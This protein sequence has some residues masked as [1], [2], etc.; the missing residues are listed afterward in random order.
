MDKFL[1]L[2]NQFKYCP[3]AFHIDTY[4]G[5]PFGCKYCF[6]NTR[7]GGFQK[8]RKNEAIDSKYLSRP[9][10]K[11]FESDK[12]FKDITVELLQHKVPLHL[13]GMSDPFQPREFSE[14]KTYELLELS[15]KHQYPIMISTKVDHLPDEYWAI[16][17]PKIHAFQVSLC[18]M[19]DDFIRRYE[20]HTPSPLN[21]V[22]FIKELRSRGFWVSVRIQP[23]IELNEALK[24]VETVNDFVN[25]ITVEH[26]KIPTDNYEIRDLFADIKE[27]YPYIKPKKSRH[28]ELTT[29]FKLKNIQK[30]KA[31]AKCPVGCAD[32]DLHRYS[33]SKCCCGVDCVGEAF[34]NYLKYNTCYF[35]VCAHNNIPVNKEELWVPQNNCKNA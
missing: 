16:L 18:G 22:N 3:N 7:A 33:D 28:Y 14:H 5:C 35:E 15:N 23:L 13:G 10:E 20:T 9:F 24:V 4:E 6:A 26:L 30:I 29:Q 19:S 25:Y 12:E 8:Q 2:S 11:A 1:S 31:I 34:D 32:N 27:K 17:D 21:R